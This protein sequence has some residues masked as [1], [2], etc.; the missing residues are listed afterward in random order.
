MA[1]GIPKTAKI[2]H[3]RLAKVAPTPNCRALKTSAIVESEYTT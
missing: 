2:H 1:E 3:P